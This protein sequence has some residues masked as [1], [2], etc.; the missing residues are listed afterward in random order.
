VLLNAR[1]EEREEHLG[2]K[3]SVLEIVFLSEDA[4]NVNLLLKKK[5]QKKSFFSRIRNRQ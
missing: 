3:N 4:E 2:G 1:E 5:P